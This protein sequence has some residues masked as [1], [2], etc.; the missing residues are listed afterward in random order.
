MRTMD[1][2]VERMKE[3]QKEVL[4][5]APEVLI[6]YL[7]WE[8]I[9]PFL[10][11]SVRAEAVGAEAFDTI[12]LTRENVISEMRDYMK[13]AWTKVED[14]RGLSAGR[15]VE[16]METWVWLLGDEEVSK[17]LDAAGYAQYGAPKLAVVCEVYGFDMPTSLHVANMIAG[18]PCTEDCEGGCGL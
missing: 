12:T 15:A 17:R 14:H 3:K 10:K 18:E 7:D 1:E 4:S 6:E 9:K 5:F 11:E 8:H 2:I 13:F 16:K